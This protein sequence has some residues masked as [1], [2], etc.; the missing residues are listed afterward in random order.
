M[1]YH[2]HGPAVLDR[3]QVHQLRTLHAARRNAATLLFAAEPMSN[4]WWKA[5]QLL[6]ACQVGISEFWREVR[7]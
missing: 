2:G 3:D 7:P 4:G 6:T 5:Q 1:I